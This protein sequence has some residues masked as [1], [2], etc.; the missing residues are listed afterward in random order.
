MGLI[1]NGTDIAEAISSPF[2]VNAFVEHPPEFVL[3]EPDVQYTHVPGKNGDIIYDDGSYQ[4]VLIKYDIAVRGSVETIGSRFAGFQTVLRGLFSKW[5]YPWDKSETGYYTLRDTYDTGHYRLARPYGQVSLK[6]IYGWNARGTLT[7]DC[8][9]ER[10]FVTVPPVETFYP[11]SGSIDNTAYNFPAKPIL[12]VRVRA[13]STGAF[14]IYQTGGNLYRVQIDN[15]PNE[16]IILNCETQ[17]A[18]LSSDGTN[19]NQY[20]TISGVGTYPVLDPGIVQSVAMTGDIM[21]LI[22]R[23]PRRWEL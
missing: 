8:R 2:I 10:Y 14:A 22:L 15:A 3:A 11:P 7:F 20:I 23:N 19:A 17:E 1:F 6:N 21:G 5:L 13:G 16:S 18:T 9:P 4:N 12:E